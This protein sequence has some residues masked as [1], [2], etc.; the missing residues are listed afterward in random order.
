[1]FQVQA[2]K[3]NTK[4]T[5]RLIALFLCTVMLIFLLDIFLIL[6]L[7]CNE[8]ERFDS[9]SESYFFEFGKTTE[10]FRVCIFT[11]AHSQCESRRFNL[12]STRQQQQNFFHAYSLSTVLKMNLHSICFSSVFLRFCFFLKKYALFHP[13]FY[14][15]I[16]ALNRQS[17][18][19]QKFFEKIFL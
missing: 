15:S 1:M 7:F 11:R 6:K 12:S 10:F 13:H 3:K 14:K 18:T 19:G 16:S 2:D 8:L 4:F 17:H 9:S 5:F